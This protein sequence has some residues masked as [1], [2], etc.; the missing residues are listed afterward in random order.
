MTIEEIIRVNEFT[1]INGLKIRRP[2][3]PPDCY[4]KI[5]DYEVLY[6]ENGQNSG[7]NGFYYQGDERKVPPYHQNLTLMKDWEIYES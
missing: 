7:V 4:F 6:Y 3:Y 1:Y 5:N 2:K